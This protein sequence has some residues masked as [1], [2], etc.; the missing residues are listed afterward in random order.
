MTIF[1][2]KFYYPADAYAKSKLAQVYFTKYLEVLFK[3]RDLKLQAHAPHPGIVDTDLF[4]HS[5][6]TYIPWFKKLVYKVSLVT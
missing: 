3:E 2:R 1:F 4:Q 6:N 5:S